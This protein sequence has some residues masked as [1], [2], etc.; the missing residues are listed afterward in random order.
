MEGLQPV[1]LP[2]G[3]AAFNQD[4]VGVVDD[5]VCDCLGNGVAGVWIGVNAGVYQPS[6]WYWVRRP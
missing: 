1:A 3:D 2:H 4:L 6:D 5:A